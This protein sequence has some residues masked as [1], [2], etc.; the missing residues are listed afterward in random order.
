MQEMPS[1]TSGRWPRR[2]SGKSR[3]L[4]WNG[5]SPPEVCFMVRQ[6]P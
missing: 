4:V 1:G 2:L 5:V 6:N 3:W